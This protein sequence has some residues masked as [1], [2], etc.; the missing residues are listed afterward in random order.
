[1]SAFRATAYTCAGRSRKLAGV[2]AK[3]TLSGGGDAFRTCGRITSCEG[4]P[5][6]SRGEILEASDTHIDK[7]H[8]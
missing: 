5:E 3:R 6:V 4:F 8:L 1:M 2:G 7:F